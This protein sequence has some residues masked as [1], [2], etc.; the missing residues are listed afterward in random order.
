LYTPQQ[1]Q[2]Q[3]QPQGQGQQG[4]GW[5]TVGSG[6]GGQKGTNPWGTQNR[7]SPESAVTDCK[8]I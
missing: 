4:G 3:Q 2:Q 5:N 7:T 1:Q 8:D 6:K